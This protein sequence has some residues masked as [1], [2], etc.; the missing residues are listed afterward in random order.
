[1]LFISHDLSVVKNVSDRVVVMYLGKVCEIGAADEIYERPAHPYTRALLASVPEPADCVE[2]GEADIS[3]ELPSAIT[4]PSGCRFHTRCP[5]ATD[6]CQTEEPVVVRMGSG[7]GAEGSGE[8]RVDG[9]AGAGDESSV[10]HFV[11]CHHPVT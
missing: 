4:P 9:A 6:I 5:R 7:D 2:P 3:G 8:A 10:D 1:M 11:A